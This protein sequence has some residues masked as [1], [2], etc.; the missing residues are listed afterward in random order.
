VVLLVVVAI[1]A[2]ALLCSREGSR[3]SACQRNLREL[4]GALAKFAT[5]DREGRFCT[6]AYDWYRDGC[7]DKVGWVADTA[8]F[9]GCRPADLCCPS[10]PARGNEGL[11]DLFVGN[12][13]I[14][15][16]GNEDPQLAVAGICGAGDST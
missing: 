16:P 15:E 11:E 3:S 9:G 14:T 2:P 5:Y 10:N 12:Y 4:G 1:A 13:L 6:G 7:P 8:K